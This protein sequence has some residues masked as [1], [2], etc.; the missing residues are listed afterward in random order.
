MMLMVKSSFRLPRGAVTAR[1]GGPNRRQFAARTADK[2]LDARLASFALL[3]SMYL[4][5]QR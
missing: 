4:R 2:P 1:P 5:S 3:D